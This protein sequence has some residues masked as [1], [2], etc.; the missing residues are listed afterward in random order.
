M[1]SR[2]DEDREHITAGP[3]WDRVLPAVEDSI[4]LLKRRGKGQGGWT[5]QI[6]DW[7]EPIA[8]ELR[9]GGRVRAEYY[10][11]WIKAEFWDPRTVGWPSHTLDGESMMVSILNA[12]DFLVQLKNMDKFLSRP[13]PE[14]E[15][16]N[17]WSQELVRTLRKALFQ[18]ATRL[19][20]GEYV[21]RSDFDAWNRPL[22]DIG[23]T[24]QKPHHKT[25][26][27]EMQYLATGPAVG[28][29][30]EV[31]QFDGQLVD[32]VGM[33]PSRAAL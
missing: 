21:S 9:A 25:D 2:S 7:Y 6:L 3:R 28:W 27:P 1:K 24:R 19:R 33:E 18:M 23:F 14:S 11:A 16:N 20:D 15:I 10:G 26:T 30:E 17:G 8:K 22:M 32:F 4:A 5:K 29:W 31:R 13:L 12:E